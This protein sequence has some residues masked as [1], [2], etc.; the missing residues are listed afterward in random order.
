MGRAAEPTPHGVASCA[1]HGETDAEVAVDPR[2]GAPVRAGVRHDDARRRATLKRPKRRPR[3]PAFRRRASLT[4]LHTTK[5]SRFG[6]TR[7]RRYTNF[8]SNRSTATADASRR[9]TST[10]SKYKDGSAGRDHTT[11]TYSCSA[12]AMFNI[13]PAASFDRVRIRDARC[14]PETTGASTRLTST[15][16]RRRG[17]R[18]RPNRRPVARSVKNDWLRLKLITSQLRTSATRSTSAYANYLGSRAPAEQRGRVPDLH[19]ERVRL[20][21]SGRTRTTSARARRKTS[22]SR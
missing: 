3:P 1:N 2:A 21:R 18:T 8:T 5:P 10:S 6:T 17:R 7:C 13:Y 11:R 16:A 9:P 20:V 12:Y 15:T 19:G 4:P 22:T 14:W